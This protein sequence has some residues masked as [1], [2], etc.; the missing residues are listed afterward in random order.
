[1][2][3]IINFIHIIIIVIIIIIIKSLIS[4][5]ILFTFD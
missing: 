1:M 4:F 3:S 5:M 2:E